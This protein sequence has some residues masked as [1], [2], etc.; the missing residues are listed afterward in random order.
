MLSLWQ[1]IV[2]LLNSTNGPNKE[3]ATAWNY[4]AYINK[5]LND[6][7]AA[8]E[9]ARRSLDLYVLNNG[10][11]DVVAATYMGMLASILA[12]QGRYDEALPLAERDFELHKIA[13]GE[14]HSYLRVLRC[15]L[16][17]LRAQCMKENPANHKASPDGNRR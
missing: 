9:A 1:Q 4:I 7:S 8:E 12:K 15:D 6:L 14:G 10:D 11:H 5:E 13:L 16:D 3:L 2:E 17:A